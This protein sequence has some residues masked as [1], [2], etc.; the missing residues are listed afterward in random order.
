[1]KKY[2]ITLIPGDGTGPDVTRAARIVLDAANVG[3]EWDVVDAGE[4]VID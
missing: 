2:T 4:G 3:I 1:M